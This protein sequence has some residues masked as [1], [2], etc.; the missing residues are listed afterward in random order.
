LR[1]AAV[2]GLAVA[3]LLP[4]RSWGQK[5]PSLSPSPGTRVGNLAQDFTLKD[6]ENRSYTLKEMRGKRVVHVVFW[7]TWCV[8]CL[9]E[10]PTLRATYD[11]YRERG[12]QVLGIAVDMGQ[13]LDGVRTAVRDLKINYPILWD[14]GGSLLERYRV[15]YIPQNFLIGKDGVIRYAGTSLPANYDTLVESLLKEDGAVAS[16]AR[17]Q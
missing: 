3:F 6:L 5:M 17:R 2:L 13:T 1:C 7:A 11:K 15:A 4:G 14:E 9:Q 8:P 10:V 12:L 16:S